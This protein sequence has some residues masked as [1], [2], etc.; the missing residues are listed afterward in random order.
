MFVALGVWLYRHRRVD[1]WLQ[2]GVIA[3]V[4]RLWAYHRLY[5]DVLVVLALVALFRIATGVDGPRDVPTAEPGRAARWRGC[6][7]STDRHVHGLHAAACA[8]RRGAAAVV[9]DFRRES[10]GV[11]ARD[12]RVPWLVGARLERQL[13]RRGIEIGNREPESGTLEAGNAPMERRELI[14][15][16]MATAGLKCL[17]GFMP[18]ELLAFGAHVH[19]SRVDATQTAGVLDAARPS[20]GRHCRRADHSRRVTRRARRMPTS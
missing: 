18:D 14:R 7:D 12:A 2:L 11:L 13:G 4:A 10:H 5:D 19:E 16:L 9:L 1:L 3:V 8:A 6:C 17:D 20:H 15:F